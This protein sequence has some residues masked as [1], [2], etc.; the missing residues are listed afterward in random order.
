MLRKSTQIFSFNVEIDTSRALAIL[1][2]FQNKLKNDGYD[3]HAQSLSR[4]QDMVQ[5]PVFNHLLNV[6][7]SMPSMIE[8]VC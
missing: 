6:Q 2:K 3:D 1:S 5:H 4:V 8:Q 7:S